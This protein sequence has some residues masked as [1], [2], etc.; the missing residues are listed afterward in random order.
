MALDMVEAKKII[1][2]FCNSKSKTKFYFN[3]FP[4]LFPDASQRD[5]K[6]VLTELV[7]EEVMEFWSSGSTTLYGLKGAGKQHAGEGEE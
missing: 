4:K 6:K 7:K 5:V 3:D 1:I 2:E